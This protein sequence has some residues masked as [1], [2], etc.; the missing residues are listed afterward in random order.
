MKLNKKYSYLFILF[1]TS[2]CNSSQSDI[3]NERKDSITNK[4]TEEIV[5]ESNQYIFKKSV[6]PNEISLIPYR[7]NM[8][9]NQLDSSLKSLSVSIDDL[10]S[11]IKKSGF[12]EG[13]ADGDLKKVFEIQKMTT[14]YFVSSI[15]LKKD[16][17]KYAISTPYENEY[18]KYLPF[19]KID[20]SY[21]F[22]GNEYEG[23]NIDPEIPLIL[24]NYLGVIKE[25]I[26]KDLYLSLLNEHI[27]NIENN[28]CEY[29]D[30]I[31]T[32]RKNIGN[33]WFEFNTITDVKPT[34]FSIYR[35]NATPKIGYP[36]EKRGN[37]S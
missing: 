31:V 23:I 15:Y 6:E 2:A 28:I 27:K 18:Q 36:I 3:N 25:N 17:I 4:K 26:S 22:N 1:L 34:I 37:C 24:I 7:N 21:N 14:T 29:G 8:P 10:T 9:I 13:D 30:Y 12:I 32:T 20:I 19:I 11:Y 5:I 33:Y 16:N 35:T